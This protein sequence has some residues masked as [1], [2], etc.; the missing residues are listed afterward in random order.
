MAAAKWTL[1]LLEKRAAGLR[2]ELRKLKQELSRA[3]DLVNECRAVQLQEA[4]QQLV[5][6][7]L[8]AENIAET[9][10]ADLDALKVVHQ[11]DV[12]TGAPNRA[13][14]LDR[15]QTALLSARRH[16]RCLAV[17]FLDLDHFKPINDRL[18][19]AT[20]DEVLQIVARVIQSMLRDSDTLCRYG[21]DEFLVLLPEISKPADARR[22]AAEMLLTISEP[23]SVGGQML[24]LSASVGISIYPQDGE[25][26]ATLIN[27]ADAA[28]YR[29]KRAKRDAFKHHG[30]G[31]LDGTDHRSSRPVERTDEAPPPHPPDAPL[32]DLRD[33]NAQLVLAALTAQQFETIAADAQ[34]QQ[35]K[36]MAVVAHALHH[37]LISLRTAAGLL[38]NRSAGADIPIEQLQVI[39]DGHVTHM[40]R[41]IDDLL[42]GS[43]L[44]NGT[45]R[46]DR[47]TF[48][49]CDVLERAVASCRPAMEARKQR[50][51]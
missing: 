47:M 11:Q 7:A 50:F 26:V 4:N 35:V 23:V 22:I 1:A 48:N 25:D 33:A 24:R 42:E 29:H 21:G 31:Q 17:L 46:I 18:G 34:H 36:L 20:G 38:V 3:R 49:L 44:S 16:Q 2:Q 27:H 19:H 9:A 39:I 40:Y 8:H 5:M 10:V 30:N 6:A 51:S 41:L 32:H 12:V 43:R 14:M 13:L 37:P 45:L 28:M 15:L